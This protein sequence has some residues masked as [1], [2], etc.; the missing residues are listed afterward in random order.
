M[1]RQ[2]NAGAKWRAAM[3]AKYGCGCEE[4][5]AKETRKMP[6]H[7][8]GSDDDRRQI[9]AD[10]ISSDDSPFTPD[11]EDA[12]R[13][14]SNDALRTV[15]DDFLPKK[16]K[17][18]AAAE[19]DEDDDDDDEGGDVKAN[20]QTI[21]RNAVAAA[22]AGLGIGTRTNDAKTDARRKVVE[23][24]ARSLLKQLGIPKPD[25]DQVRAVVDAFIAQLDSEN[26]AVK[27]TSGHGDTTEDTVEDTVKQQA[28]EYEARGDRKGANFLDGMA[29]VRADNEARM[30]RSNAYIA[31]N[32]VRAANTA[33]DDP[34]VKAMTEHSGGVVAMIQKRG[35]V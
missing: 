5:R 12:L 2:A 35:K 1:K 3:D 23:K 15:R 21:V 11:D 32:P 27:G 33:S 13:M 26:G 17:A 31:R 9:I 16:A 19:N 10:L 4:C 24:Q 14:M 7:A 22:L 20:L 18:K 8:R 29:A 25:D 28:R 30:A 34:A 6:R